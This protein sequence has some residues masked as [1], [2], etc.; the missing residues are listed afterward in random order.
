MFEKKTKVCMK[1]VFNLHILQSIFYTMNKSHYPQ[2]VPCEY[3]A[4]TYI[5]SLNNS[6]YRF[7]FV[8]LSHAMLCH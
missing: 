7:Q 2:F 3:G 5:I 4:L 6:F 8:A 1:P